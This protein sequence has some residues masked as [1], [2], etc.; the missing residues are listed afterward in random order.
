MAVCMLNVEKDLD[1]M[2]TLAYPVHQSEIHLD[3][4]YIW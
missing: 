2:T 3:E 1:Q 4:E